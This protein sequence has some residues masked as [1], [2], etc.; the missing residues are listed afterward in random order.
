MKPEWYRKSTRAVHSGEANEQ[1]K[2]QSFDLRMSLASIKICLK[3]LLFS[4]AL[5]PFAFLCCVMN[6]SCP[7]FAIVALCL[8]ATLTQ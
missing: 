5:L 2:L 7:D 4:S 8:K 1:A 6:V 3:F